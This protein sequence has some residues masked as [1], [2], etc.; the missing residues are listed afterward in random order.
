MD[1]TDASEAE[2]AQDGVDQTF[3][4]PCSIA[5]ENAKDIDCDDA[6][7]L[8]DGADEDDEDDEDF[9]AKGTLCG[10]TLQSTRTV[11]E[12]TVEEEKTWTTLDSVHS[13][14]S[15][16]FDPGCNASFNNSADSFNSFGG[17]SGTLDEYDLEELRES[18]A[19]FKKLDECQSPKRLLDIETPKRGLQLLASRSS[20]ARMIRGPSFRGTLSL[21]NEDSLD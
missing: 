17:S 7:S 13:K 20:S 19:E 21:I 5:L 10:Y 14:A 9:G 15:T 16:R 2:L 6:G 12:L 18:Q 4:L 8:E 3:I 1:A 11:Q